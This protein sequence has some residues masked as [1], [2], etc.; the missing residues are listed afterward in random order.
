MLSRRLPLPSIG[1][2]ISLAG[3]KAITIDT[4]LPS[5]TFTS[6]SPTSP[7][8]S[9]NPTLTINVSEALAT[10]TLYSNS[11]CATAISASVAAPQG[12]NTLTTPTLTGNANTSI[13]AQGTDQ[14]GNVSVCGYMTA[15]AQSN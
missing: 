12:V 14:A 11:S 8:T 3:Q 7:G 6:I 5:L 1:G 4:I 10:L 9:P 2:L 13:F 15:Y